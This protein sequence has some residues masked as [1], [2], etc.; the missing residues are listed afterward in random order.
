MKKL[1]LLAAVAAMAGTGAAAPN[2]DMWEHVKDNPELREGYL[3][4]KAGSLQ[5]YL[6][7]DKTP[8]RRIVWK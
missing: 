5:K 4:K 3:A 2:V 7:M 6:E 1:T 8:G